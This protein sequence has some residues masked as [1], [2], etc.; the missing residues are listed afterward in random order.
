MIIFVYVNLCACILQ[1]C[2]TMHMNVLVYHIGNFARISL[3][4]DLRMHTIQDQSPLCAC[5]D[6]GCLWE[7]LHLCMHAYACVYHLC[8]YLM[9]LGACVCSC[10]VGDDRQLGRR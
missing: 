2:G 4:W 3:E 8:N 1:M 7:P 10:S 9:R 6:S 5:V